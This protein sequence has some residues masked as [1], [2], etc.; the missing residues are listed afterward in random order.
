LIRYLP[1]RLTEYRVRWQ[2][3]DLSDG[4]RPRVVARKADLRRVPQDAETP[5]GAQ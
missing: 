3:I 2:D 1:L 5:S 4:R